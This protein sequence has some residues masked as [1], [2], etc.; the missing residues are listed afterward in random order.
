KKGE[1]ID[2]YEKGL[3]DDW[4][5]EYRYSSFRLVKPQQFKATPAQW[6]ESRIVVSLDDIKDNLKSQEYV[7]RVE[8]DGLLTYAT[9]D[10]IFKI[11]NVPPKAKSVSIATEKNKLVEIKLDATDLDGDQLSYSIVSDPSHGIL[12]NMEPNTGK[13]TYTPSKD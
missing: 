1:N 4:A 13:L 10:S 8:K 3:V 11:T 7:V 12:S 9:T 6:D 2:A 5:E